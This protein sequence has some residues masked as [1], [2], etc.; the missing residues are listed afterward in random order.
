MLNESPAWY[1]TEALA[2]GAVAVILNR[3]TAPAEAGGATF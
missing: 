2:V 1:M 3:E